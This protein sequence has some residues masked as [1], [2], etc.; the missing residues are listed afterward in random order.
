VPLSPDGAEK[1]PRR[2]LG[3]RE[4]QGVSGRGMGRNETI[5]HI[6]QALLVLMAGSALRVRLSHWQPLRAISIMARGL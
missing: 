1:L 3:E 2:F 4:L 5:W 6:F